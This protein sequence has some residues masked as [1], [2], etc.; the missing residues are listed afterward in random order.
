MEEETT[1]T[2]H[3]L[4][5]EIPT[6]HKGPLD[7]PHLSPLTSFLR[8]LGDTQLLV[9]S[10]LLPCTCG[11]SDICRGARSSAGLLAIQLPTQEAVVQVPGPPVPALE[12]LRMGKQ[13]FRVSNWDI[14]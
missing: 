7:G 6:V 14:V 9:L 12:S 8:A 1:G 11:K 2:E 3:E 13:F 5:M 10:Y 4:G